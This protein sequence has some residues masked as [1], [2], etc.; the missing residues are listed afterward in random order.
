MRL[1]VPTIKGHSQIQKIGVLYWHFDPKNYEKSLDGIKK[2]RNYNFEDTCVL[3][4][5]TPDIE[6]KKITFFEEHIHKDEEVRFFLE[7]SG[8]FDVRANNDK[9]IRMHCV[10]G[11]LLVLPAGIYHRFSLDEQGT[12]RVLRLFQGEPVWTPYNRSKET[13]GFKERKE[14]QRYLAVTADDEDESSSEAADDGSDDD[15][16]GEDDSDDG[17]DATP[18]SSSSADSDFSD[19]DDDSEERPKKRKRPADNGAVKRK[20]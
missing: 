16:E 13:D 19:S 7:G 6:K 9:W 17:D 14:Y 12:T 3:G 1:K 5:D 10:P 4:P 11:D 8:Y 15:F 20:K 2:R 18:S